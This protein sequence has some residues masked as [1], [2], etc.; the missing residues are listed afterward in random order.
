MSVAAPDVGVRREEV[1]EEC[2]SNLENAPIPTPVCRRNDSWTCPWSLPCV[3]FLSSLQNLHVTSTYIVSAQIFA[4]SVDEHLAGNQQLG[5][6]VKGQR[7]KCA[8]GI[9]LEVAA[10]YSSTRRFL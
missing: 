7:A 8:N 9:R 3:A 10:G 6:P 4:L 1:E 5:G 2:H